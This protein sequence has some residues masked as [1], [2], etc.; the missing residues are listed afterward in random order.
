MARLLQPSGKTTSVLLVGNAH[1]GSLA[2]G[3]ALKAG[4][5]EPYLAVY[6]SG[7]Y[8]GRSRANAGSV[9]VPDPKLDG[10]GFVRKL[11]AAAELLSVAAVLP[12][13]DSHLLTLAGHETDFA[14]IA[15]GTPS[16][17]IVERATDKGLLATLAATAG[18]RTP[19]TERVI[20]GDSE[21][22]GIFGFPAILK[23]R[24]SRMQ[25]PEGT[26]SVLKVRYVSTEQAAEEAFETF[27]DKEGFIQP[28]IPGLLCSVAGVSWEGEL[29][30][31]LHQRSPRIWPLPTGESAYA[32]TVPPDV[33]LE[34]GVGRLLQALGW[35][36]LFQAQF[37]RSWQGAHYLIDFNPRAYGSL[38]LATTAGLNLPCIWTDLLLGRPPD[39]GSYRLGVH[40]R[41][42]EKDARALGQML[43]AGRGPRHVLQGLVPKRHTAHAVF[44]LRDPMPL[45]TSGEKLAGRLGHLFRGRPGL[46]SKTRRGARI[47]PALEHEGACSTAGLRGV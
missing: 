47:F 16:L 5:Y 40:Y 37:I 29:V 21:T 22:M 24:R 42:E 11:A 43:A 33:E 19:P 30:C 25:N 34:Q 1:Y 23:P 2:M 28:Y 6:G 31:A 12:S 20:R 46:S 39:V 35:S 18:L 4:G 8:V 36:G 10:E 27:P 32:E 13:A 15:L 38:A 17:D 14:G 44:S 7:T 45:L 26:L 3:R 9:L 41:H